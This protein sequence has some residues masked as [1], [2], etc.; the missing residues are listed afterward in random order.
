MIVIL[1]QTQKVS[2]LDIGEKNGQMAD[3][4][5]VDFTSSAGENMAV[6]SFDLKKLKASGIREFYLENID[7]LGP[8]PGSDR[9]SHAIPI[10]LNDA[11][12]FF[13]PHG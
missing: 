12:D 8:R 11:G 2:N 7:L 10:H 1:F 4:S 13:L 6:F 3:Q 9:D 5:R